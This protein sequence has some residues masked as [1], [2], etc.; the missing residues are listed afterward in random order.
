MK[1]AEFRTRILEALRAGTSEFSLPNLARETGAS[2][3]TVHEVTR[4]VFAKYIARLVEDGD[5]TAAER[6]KASILAAKLSIEE[7]EAKEIVMKAG[8]QRYRTELLAAH[9]DGVVTDAEEAGLYQ[10]RVQLGLPVVQIKNDENQVAPATDSTREQSAL[11][12]VAGIVPFS[13]EALANRR[14]ESTN[15]A[16]G[17][18]FDLDQVQQIDKEAERRISKWIL[19]T[20]VSVICLLGSFAWLLFAA[21][22]EGSTW[23]PGVILGLSVVS[24]V[25]SIV[26]MQ[27]GNPD[28]DDHRYLVI[29]DAI[30]FLACDMADDQ[31]V[32]ASIDFG[33][34][35][36][37]TNLVEQTG[38]GFFSSI[39][40][41]KY[42]HPW[43]NVKGRLLDGTRFRLEV[44]RTVK[45]KEKSK[46][47]YTKVSETFTDK[48]DLT[49]A[50]RPKTV[51]LL[52]AAARRLQQRPSYNGVTVRNVAVQ[53]NKLI[54]QAASPP[55][56]RVK[57]RYNT[58][59]QNADRHTTSHH[60]L[61]GLF[62]ACYDSL[63]R[64]RLSS[65]SNA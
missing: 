18:L 65:S 12:M 39:R 38:G 20:V 4:N 33:D 10:L 48:I 49:L 52:E 5:Y 2:E 54:V 16:R 53:G 25:F 1:S 6:A 59:N 24:L 29:K 58:T 55:L 50:V 62:L 64:A 34:Y 36:Q 40:V 8:E 47:K 63:G 46:R 61:L 9:E 41:K 56:R 57:G 32:K 51:P 35:N 26:K 28:L 23:L 21:G 11:P 15:T 30:R 3:Q 19:P 27:S 14:F 13:K 45:R 37:P 31:L 60:Q 42:D 44:S 7:P 43:A 17:L 22:L